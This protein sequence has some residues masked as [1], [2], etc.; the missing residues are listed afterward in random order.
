MMVT[1]LIPGALRGECGGRAR[2]PVPA[3]AGWTLRQVL[4][5][6]SAQY[7]RFDR[8][9]RDEQ[10]RLRRYVNVF[11]GMDECRTLSGLDTEVVDGAQVH[12]LPSVAGG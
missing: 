1:V 11:V 2:M 7:P 4:D 9:V 12:I 5:A 3:E 6:V 8:R 10:G